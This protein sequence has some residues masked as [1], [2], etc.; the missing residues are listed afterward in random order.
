[1]DIIQEKYQKVC[2]VFA[3]NVTNNYFQMKKYNLKGQWREYSWS[4]HI[5]LR[6]KYNRIA[7]SLFKQNFPNSKRQCWWIDVCL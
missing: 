3:L 1:M 7:K 5:W 4:N 6:Y 2:A